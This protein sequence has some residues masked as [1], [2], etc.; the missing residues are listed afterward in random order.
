V[1]RRAGQLEAFDRAQPQRLVVSAVEELRGPDRLTVATEDLQ[2]DVHL[3]V[4][5][6]G[7]ELTDAPRS[8]V[9][10]NE[11]VSRQAVAHRRRGVAVYRAEVALAVDQQVARREVLRQT[12]Q[13]VVDRLVA[14]GVVLLHH[15]TDEGR[16]LPERTVRAQAGLQR[17]VED[18]PVHRLQS[19]AHVGERA[20]H[21]HRHRVLEEGVLDL[22]LDGYVGYRRVVAVAAGE[23]GLDWIVSHSLLD[24]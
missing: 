24:V 22:L 20:R 4:R 5:G 8:I 23:P 9:R 3:G 1:V 19:V 6:G 13:R 12:G 7:G 18:A 15:V 21:D 16:A 10:P 11:R 2:V 14:V 17:R